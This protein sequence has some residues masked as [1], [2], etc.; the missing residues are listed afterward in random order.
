MPTPDISVP[1]RQAALAL[2]DQIAESVAHLPDAA[3]LV[4]EWRDQSLSK[5][6]AGIAVLHAVQAR[7]GIGGRD[8]AHA[9]LS[10][11]ARNALNTGPSAGLWWGA[12]AVAFAIAVTAPDNPESGPPGGHYQSARRALDTAVAD[13]TRARLQAAADRIAAAVRPPRAEYD[14]VSGLTGLGAYL[15]HRAPAGGLLRDVLTY[16]TRL[17]DPV[18]AGDDAGAGVPGWWTSD[19]P[20]GRPE[21]RFAGGHGDLGVAHGITGPLALLSLA[22][23]RGIT[24][25]GQ[26]DA[27]DRICR[28]LDH[29][30]Q[31]GPAGSWW[32]MRVPWPDVRAEQTTED[33]PA[34]PSWCYGTP[35][36][37]RAQQLAGL[38]LGD[39]DRQH[40][41]ERVLLACVSDPAQLGQLTDPALCHGWAGLVATVWHA[42]A[43]ASSPALASRL[44]GLVDTLI[45]RTETAGAC[46][47]WL[48][49][50][51]AGVAVTLHILTH[52][53]T[54]P[55]GWP[56]CLLLS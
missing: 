11:A 24:V 42:A 54:A 34:R 36:I 17:A 22:M 5:G 47:P 30:Q 52:P 8:L 19:I 13:L 16:L 38:A 33:G 12:P 9:W 55:A 44:P 37:T 28:W 3:E 50:G 53:S 46:P 41:A 32:P 27:I 14:L 40:R 20:L 21:E 49:E 10:R 48:I 45:T 31:D 51:T 56:T 6:A 35:G 43:D 2:A 39:T 25:P 23:R 18:S 15:L 26:A 4:P 7:A 1:R 29:W